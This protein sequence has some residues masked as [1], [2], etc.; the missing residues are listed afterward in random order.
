MKGVLLPAE[1]LDT[2]RLLQGANLSALVR[3]VVRP[4]TGHSQRVAVCVGETDRCGARVMA[5]L[6]TAEEVLR[7]ADYRGFFFGVPSGVAC[8]AYVRLPLRLGTPP[9]TSKIS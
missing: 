2:S 3:Y 7:L 9:T 8:S 6:G 5:P 4:T 1:E